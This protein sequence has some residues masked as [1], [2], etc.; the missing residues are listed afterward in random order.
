MNIG[1][2]LKD[3][4]IESG[5]TQEQVAEQ[6]DVSRQTIS[7]WE[8][9]RTFPDIVSVVSL[10]DIYDVS[11]DVLI[12]GDEKMLEHLE[13][14]TNIVKS[15]KKLLFAIIANILTA[16]AMIG[17]SVIVPS[18]EYVLAGVFCVMVITA[19]FLMHQIVKRI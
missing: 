4:R 15:N 6:L 16:I 13:E 11:L 5:Y 8:N 10:S 3:A 18:N 19:S 2:R 7:S 17:L 1:K 14:S 12:K 9:G